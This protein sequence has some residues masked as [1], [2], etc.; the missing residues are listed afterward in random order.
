MWNNQKQQIS[1]ADLRE[2]KSYRRCEPHKGP[3]YSTISAI[4]N[5]DRMKIGDERECRKF[6]TPS[7]QSSVFVFNK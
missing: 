2:K 1:K 6:H 4:F 7:D 3:S 5:K